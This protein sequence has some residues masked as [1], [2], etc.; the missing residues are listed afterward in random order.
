[1]LAF[2]QV[3]AWT[4]GHKEA[5]AFMAPGF[6]MHR[7]NF[8]PALA[9]ALAPHRYDEAFPDR[10]TALPVWQQMQTGDGGGPAIEFSWV[11]IP[12]VATMPHSLARDP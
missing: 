4:S 6:S 7:H 5:M 12:R 2:I 9:I 1:V 3:V 10:A 8:C 11:G